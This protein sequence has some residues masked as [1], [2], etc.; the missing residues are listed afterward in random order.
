MEV[1]AKRLKWLREKERYSQKDI[2]DKIGMTASGYQKIERDERDPKLDVLVKLCSIYKVSSDFL[3]GISDIVGGL[4]QL[5]DEFYM[6]RTKK[7][8]KSHELESVNYKMYDIYSLKTLPDYDPKTNREHELEELV[9]KERK[10]ALEKEL[11]IIQEEYRETIFNYIKTLLEIPYSNFSR[12]PIIKMLQPFSIEIQP[13]IFDEFS[14]VIFCKE[15]FVENYEI[16]KIEEDALEARRGLLTIL[17]GK[18]H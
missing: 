9:L 8:M 2:A 1:L 14:L 11:Y 10:V 4:G 18:L 7:A 6:I 16:Y 17:N 15:G 13:N 5:S 12:N 3:L